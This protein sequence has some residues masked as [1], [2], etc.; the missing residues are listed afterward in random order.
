MERS[1]EKSSGSGIAEQCG[2]VNPEECL[3]ERGHKRTLCSSKEQTW[4]YPA[5][6]EL[7]K[8]REGYITIGHGLALRRKSVKR[9]STSYQTQAV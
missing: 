7:Y 3:G 2:N 1:V 6:N 8:E 5:E 9:G 4:N